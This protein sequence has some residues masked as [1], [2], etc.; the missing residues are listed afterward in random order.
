MV[1]AAL[2]RNRRYFLRCHV[3]GFIDFAHPFERFADALEE[4]NRLDKDLA[5][6]GPHTVTAEEWAPE[7]AA[8]HDGT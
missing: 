4:A 3:D 6:C 7:E 1:S 2:M 5:L 8:D